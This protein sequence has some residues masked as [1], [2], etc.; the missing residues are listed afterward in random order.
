MN[1][2]A[3]REQRC[4]RCEAAVIWANRDGGAPIAVERCAPR[5]GDVGFQKQIDGTEQLVSM[6]GMGWRRHRCPEGPAGAFSSM[7]KKKKR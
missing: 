6:R 1:A 4:Y 7:G 2:P 5:T 3:R